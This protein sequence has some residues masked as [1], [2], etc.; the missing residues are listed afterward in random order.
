M[1]RSFHNDKGIISSKKKQQA[2]AQAANAR[3]PKYMKQILVEW[4]KNTIC[5]YI[6]NLNSLLSVTDETSRQK[7]SKDILKT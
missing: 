1:K 7:L 4:P 5:N 3:P 6:R 2:N